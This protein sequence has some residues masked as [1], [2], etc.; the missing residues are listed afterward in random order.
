M[1]YQYPWATQEMAPVTRVPEVFSRTA[2]KLVVE[3]E[4]RIRGTATV[5]PPLKVSVTSGATRNCRE[6]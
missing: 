4:P 2:V 1:P 3:T 5:V 6:K